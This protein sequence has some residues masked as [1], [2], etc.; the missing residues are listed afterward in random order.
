M[1]D[2][3]RAQIASIAAVHGT[4]VDSAAPLDT[5]S[6]I[7]ALYES[8]DHANRVSFNRSTIGFSTAC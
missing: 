4:N 3:Q 6:A 1:K 2:E 5:D 7:G 8:S